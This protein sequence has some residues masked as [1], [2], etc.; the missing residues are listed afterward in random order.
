MGDTWL[1]MNEREV[2]Q[3]E[4]ALTQAGWAEHV[5]LEREIR[6]WARLAREVDAYDATVDDYTN[7]LCS[8]DYIAEFAARASSGLQRVI[9]ERVGPV[10]ETFRDGTVDDDDARLG[11]YFRIDQEDA[12]WWHRR[13]SAGPLA[14]YLAIE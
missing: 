9:Q 6:V 4:V 11:R 13:P 14:D 8:R 1:V 5:R 12:W 10:D 2:R 3:I 7:D